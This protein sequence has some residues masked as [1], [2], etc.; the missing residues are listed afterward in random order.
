MLVIPFV[1]LNGTSKS[2]LLALREQVYAA[3]DEAAAALRQMA[4]N[5]RDYYLEPGRFE[6]AVAQH[7]SRIKAIRDIMAEL[8][9]ECE[10]INAV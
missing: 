9:K 8:E 1:H 10:A 4:P 7:D 6:E 3:L 5:G 2:E